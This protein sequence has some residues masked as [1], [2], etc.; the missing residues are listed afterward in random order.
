[1]T[2][3]RDGFLS[4]APELARQNDG[5]D[6][7]S[8][9]ALAEAEPGHFWFRG[10]NA[11]ILWALRRYFPNAA[12]FL[13]VG[14]GTGFV[15]SGVAGSFPELRL[16]GSEIYT[17]GLGFAARR[18]PRAE[19]EQMDGRRLPY[20]GEFVVA[21]G[22]DVIE[23]IEEDQLVLENLYRATKPGGGCLLTV[24]QH[25]WLWSAADEVA[26]HKRRYRR[27]DLHEKVA[28]AGF[29]VLRS[30][31]F[32]S[33]LLPL[34]ALARRT[35]ARN[36]NSVEQESLHVNPVLNG[37]LEQVLGLERLL[38]RVGLDLPVGGSRLVVAKRD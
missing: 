17:E 2:E 25:P 24:P 6:P 38:I 26:C 21:A 27:Q 10:R 1:M 33:F 23:H 12:S 8:F 35:R 9:R 31:S 29:R 22:F 3:R 14:C 28:A 5:F 36:R 20:V 37:L 11:I 30:T 34:L 13:E 16:A 4:W 15:L 7:A 18:V 32:V 19:L